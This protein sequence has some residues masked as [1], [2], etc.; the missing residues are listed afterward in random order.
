MTLKSAEDVYIDNDNFHHIGFNP[1][2]WY[3]KPLPPELEKFL[4][5][6]TKPVVY[7]SM[8]TVFQITEQQL[9]M[10]LEELSRQT[11]YSIIWS[12]SLQYDSI[13]QSGK[14]LNDDGKLLLVSK[15]PQFTL[16]NHGRV[17][18]FITHAGWKHFNHKRSFSTILAGLSSP[19]FLPNCD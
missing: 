10:L 15:I 4:E 9:G 18:V 6:S 14:Y 5:K 8:G 7:M 16:L 17:Q 1:D 19:M 3:C 13:R 12:I 2:E 11:S